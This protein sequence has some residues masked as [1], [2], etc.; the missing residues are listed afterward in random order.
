MQLLE[1]IIGGLRSA[2]QTTLQ[3][4]ELFRT[5]AGI[6]TRKEEW[7]VANVSEYVAMARDTRGETQ[8][9]FDLLHKYAASPGFSDACR[10]RLKYRCLPVYLAGL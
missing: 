9:L 10:K 5:M 8:R 1:V 7:C 6:A 2:A 4:P 3:A